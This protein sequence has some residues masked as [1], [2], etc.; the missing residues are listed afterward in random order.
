MTR[1]IAACAVLLL[2]AA[3]AARSPRVSEWDRA[4]EETAA[5]GSAQGSTLTN[6][7]MVEKYGPPDR[8]GEDR[9]V[10][11]DRGPWKRI[12]VWDELGFL[13]NSAAGRNIESTVVYPVPADKRMELSS[14]SGAVR[15]SADGHE[16]SAR[17]TDEERNMLMLN[18]ADGIV[19]GRL[20]VEEA[21]AGYLRALRLDAAGK[22][23]PEM[24]RLQFR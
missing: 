9:L 21:R 20:T 8:M 18:L 4:R 1:P 6:E 16:L 19:K 10:W 23:Q 24:R 13:D 2:V 14:F 17:S 5:R 7:K 22:D 12:V 3:C 15:V 11:E